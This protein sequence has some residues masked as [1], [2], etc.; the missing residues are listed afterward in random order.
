MPPKPHQPPSN[1]QSG[2]QMILRIDEGPFAGWVIRDDVIWT[3]ENEGYSKGDIRAI[4]FQRQL[5]Q[6]QR[7]QLREYWQRRHDKQEEKQRQIF[8]QF[9]VL[10]SLI[11]Q[12]GY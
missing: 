7:R 6:E 4:H 8:R 9:K 10:Q 5:V 11:E 1:A 2:E 12:S 3:P